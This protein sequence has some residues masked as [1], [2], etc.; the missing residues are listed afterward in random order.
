MYLL[1][2]IHNRLNDVPGRPVI[3]NCG[4]PTENLSE[5]L[6]HHLQPIIQ[7]GK[8]YIKDTSDFLENLKNLGNIP[9]NAIL[10]T[11]DVVALYPSIPH[12]AGLQALFEKL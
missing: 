6:D 5:F 4:T 1:P 3:S 2:K 9:S 8:S 10:V 7:A 12:D 11:A